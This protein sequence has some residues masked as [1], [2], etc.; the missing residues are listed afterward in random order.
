MTSYAKQPVPR[1][2]GLQQPPAE[3]HH[4]QEEHHIQI[5]PEELAHSFED[6]SPPA[7]LSHYAIEDW[8]TVA[9]FWLMAGAVFLQF[10]TR[11]VLNDSLNW[12]EEIASYCLV[13]LVFV[14]SAMCVRLSRHIQVDILYRFL[15]DGP[16]RLFS[17]LV[18]VIRT[19]FLM[20]LT[21][22]MWRLS[23]VVGDEMMVTVQLSKG[24]LYYSVL[25]GCAL[26]AVRS[27]QVTIV[28]W[29][30]GY[31]VLEKPEAFDGTGV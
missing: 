23:E 6:D 4:G 16:A 7:D 2:A 30:R 21:H 25:A 24:I 11:Y 19:T 29:R 9:L 10:F 31:S 18:D 13:A 14:G 15:P 5:S 26:M 8:A 28:N 12:T 3:Q 20:Y 17:T 27:L 1:G 22:L